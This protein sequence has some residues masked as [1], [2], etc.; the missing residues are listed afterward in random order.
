MVSYVLLPDSR[1]VAP[2][3]R[4]KVL[5]AI[6]ELGYRPNAIAQALRRGPTSSI[7]LLV[8]DHTN[9]FG[10]WVTMGFRRPFTPDASRVE[11]AWAGDPGFSR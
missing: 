11:D 7:G 10:D 1:P 8:P 5:A 4:K 9:P 2:A 6:E 3:T